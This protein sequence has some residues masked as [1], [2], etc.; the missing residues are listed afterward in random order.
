MRCAICD[1]ALIASQK[2][3]EDM[4]SAC[5]HEVRKALGYLDHFV[6]DWSIEG[7]D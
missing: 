3:E 4:C 6:Y 5:K 2:V 7:E 1:K